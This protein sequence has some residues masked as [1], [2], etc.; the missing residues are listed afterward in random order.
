MLRGYID[1]PRF[2]L[3]TNVTC[4]VV[5]PPHV[6]SPK[7]AVVLARRGA[8]VAMSGDFGSFALRRLGG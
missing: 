6:A 5:V 1:G 8:D 7:P 4:D 3:S 2:R